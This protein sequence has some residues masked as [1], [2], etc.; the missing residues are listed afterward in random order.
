MRLASGGSR[1][2]SRRMNERR[3]RKVR[4]MAAVCLR[5]GGPA[6]RLANGPG[7]D[8]RRQAR[9]V[10]AARNQEGDV[11]AIYG[12]VS[13]QRE[14]CQDCGDVAFVLSGKM[15]C[16]G[17]PLEAEAGK[18]R[19]MSASSGVRQMPAMEERRGILD[20]QGG[21]CFYC[22]TVFGDVAHKDGRPPRV[23]GVCW[24]HVEPFCWQSNNQPLNFVAACAICNGIKGSKVFPAHSDAIAYVWHRRARKGWRTASEI[25]PEN[26]PNEQE[27]A[28]SPGGV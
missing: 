18:P 20:R 21:R 19:R 9:Q 3:L 5:G 6:R 14:R 4:D 11:K 16:C 24:D 25:A 8:E 22:G 27:A 13:I 10:P 1:S 28:T 7:R 26:R 2:P 15:A 23:L 17:L 12:S